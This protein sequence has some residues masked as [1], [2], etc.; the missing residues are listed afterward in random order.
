[1]PS[2]IILNFG[3]GDLHR[4]YPTV[5]AQLWE[6]D[7]PQPIQFTGSLPATP[8]I[9]N[10]YHHWRSGYEALYSHLNWRRSAT[11]LFEIDETDETHISL[12]DFDAL[13]QQLQQ[14]FNAW[15]NASTFQPLEQQLRTHLNPQDEIRIILV[16]DDTTLLKMPWHLWKF[17]E[18]YHSA[19]IAV[20]PTDYNRSQKRKNSSHPRQQQRHRHRKRS[21]ITRIPPPRRNL[22]PSRTHH[23]KFNRTSLETRMGH[24]IFR[25]P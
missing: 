11:N 23:P 12:E 4:G 2:L 13:C 14:Q 16:T 25:R 10:L 5:T 15:L 1:M 7:R 20:S 17:L 6:N 24:P 9:T 22:L 3:K 18:D 8:E 19:E 21:Q